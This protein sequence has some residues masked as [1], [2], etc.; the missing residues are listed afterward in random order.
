M[1]KSFIYLTRIFVIL[2]IL[3]A[4]T[5]ED[6]APSNTMATGHLKLLITDDPIAW[7]N[8]EEVNV[9]VEKIF[10]RKSDAGD[11]DPDEGEDSL[12]NDNMRWTG[13]GSSHSDSSRRDDYGWEGNDSSAF[14]VVL[15][16]PMEINLLELRNGVTELLAELDVPAG[17]YDQVRIFI[18]GASLVM[19][20]GTE[21][22]LEIPSALTSGLKIIIHPAM[23]IEEGMTEELLL[24]ID[25]SRSLVVMGSNENP[26]GYKF[27]PVIRSVPNSASGR[28]EGFVTEMSD[29]G[30]SNASVWLEGE[31]VTSS[32]IS[33]EAG[34]YK[35]IG[36]PPGDYTLFAVKADYDTITIANV[37]IN[38]EG[39]TR[40]NV[41]L[42]PLNLNGN[43]MDI[44]PGKLFKIINREMVAE[45]FSWR[46]YRHNIAVA[47]R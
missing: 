42:T 17:T 44:D 6:D 18:S 21:F 38:I 24:D 23:V 43:F 4:C 16:S 26:Q 40:V 31:S 12:E 8:I 14:I 27:T 1:K 37:H 47:S 41:Q 7:E 33:N 34:F 46:S 20:D 39:M 3:G 36:I 13:E 30:V 15:N 11:E 10:I 28:I 19:S 32:A 35:M 5:P 25:L 29:N 9:V 22:E 2:L 45:N